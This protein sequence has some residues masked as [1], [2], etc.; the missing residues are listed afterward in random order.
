M[1]AGFVLGSG[2]R[3]RW[4]GQQAPL[5]MFRWLSGVT[6]GRVGFRAELRGHRCEGCRVILA[7]Y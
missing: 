6:I 1:V 7:R 4:V 5:G 2:S 3:L